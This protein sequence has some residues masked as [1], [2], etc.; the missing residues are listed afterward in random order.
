MTTIQMFQVNEEDLDF[1]NKLHCV[2]EL[3][4]RW[5]YALPAW[6]PTDFDFDAA[7][8]KNGLRSYEVDEFRNVPEFDPKTGHKKV[9]PIECF[10]GIYRDLQGNMYDLRP[11]ESAPSLINFQRMSKEK[12]RG[13]LMNAYQE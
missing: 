5:W 10:E 11:L 2:D 9:H 3:A 12:V 4:N 1:G 13:L 8:A 6:P 7:L